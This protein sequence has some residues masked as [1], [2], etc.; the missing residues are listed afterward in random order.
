MFSESKNPTNNKD[1]IQEIQEEQ[2]TFNMKIL[3]N[4]D[5]LE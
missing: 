5:T 3:R 1:S 2:L 4:F